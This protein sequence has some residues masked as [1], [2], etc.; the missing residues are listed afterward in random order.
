MRIKFP[1]KDRTVKRAANLSVDAALLDEAKA[2]KINLSQTLETGLRREVAVRRI[3]LWREENAAA[4]DL[5]NDW[6]EQNGLPLGRY[7]QF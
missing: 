2:F 6:V 7:R 5:Y 3:A 4:V 1:I